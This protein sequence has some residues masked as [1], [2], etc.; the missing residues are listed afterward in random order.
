MRQLTTQE[1]QIL[2]GSKERAIF[3]EEELTALSEGNA[4]FKVHAMADKILQKH[5]SHMMGAISRQ[6]AA[7]VFMLNQMFQHFLQNEFAPRINRAMNAIQ[8]MKDKGLITED[9]IT[10]INSGTGRKADEESL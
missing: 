5:N 2:K 7:S 3:S 1:L 10:K 8:V 4:S 6:E 9:D